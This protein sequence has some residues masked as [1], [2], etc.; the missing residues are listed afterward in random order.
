MVRVVAKVALWSSAVLVV[1]FLLAFWGIFLSP[2]PPVTT[3]PATLAGDGS[4][5]DYCVLPAL[6]GS[7]KLRPLPATDL[8]RVH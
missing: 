3:D 6:D 7:G 1:G 8:G 4:M 5:I 2:R